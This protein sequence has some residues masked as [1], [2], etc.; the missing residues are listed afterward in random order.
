MIFF[1]KILKEYGLYFVAFALGFILA[2]QGCNESVIKEVI[3]V[4]KPIPTIEYIE[5]RDTLRFAIRDS[6]IDTI[7]DTLTN[8]I[9]KINTDTILTVD[10]L[11]IIETWL[12]EL[13]RYDTTLTFDN[14]AV[15][16]KWE[17]YQNLTEN[18]QVALL[19]QTS[20]KLNINVYAKLGIRSDFNSIYKPVVGAGLMFERKRLIFGADYGYS[21]QHN[22]NGVL[23]YR[24]R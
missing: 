1:T 8:E 16:V 18:L 10:T 12:T 7:R 22:I 13:V 3:T 4:D 19:S 2:N 9:I 11:K 5:V 23:G 17:N 14:D 21:G 20:K 15:N 6:R 24:L